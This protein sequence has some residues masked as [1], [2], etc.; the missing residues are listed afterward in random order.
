MEKCISINAFNNITQG[1][2]S[3]SHHDLLKIHVYNLAHLVSVALFSIKNVMNIH[4]PIFCSFSNKCT[5]TLRTLTI[6][7]KFC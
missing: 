5:S 1:V 2:F 6:V 4:M 7:N 3:K